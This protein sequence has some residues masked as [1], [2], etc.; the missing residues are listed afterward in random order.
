MKQILRGILFVALIPALSACF[1]VTPNVEMQQMSIPITRQHDLNVALIASDVTR[2]FNTAHEI[3]GACWSGGMQFAAA[4]YGEILANSLQ[5]RFSYLFSSVTVLNTVTDIEDY[6]A[7]FSVDINDAGMRFACGISPTQFVEIKGSLQSLREDGSP[8]WVSTKSTG[9]Y[10]AGMSY[11][12]DF[13]RIYGE[14]FSKAIAKLVDDWVLELQMI[15]PPQYAFNIDPDDYERGGIYASNSNSNFSKRNKGFS[16]KP[17]KIKYPAAPEDPDDIMV[18]IGNAN[19]SRQSKD[20]PDVTPAYSDA[21][22]MKK[23]AIQALGIREGNIID[24]RD[25][26]SA[27]I[28]SVF[29]SKTNYKGQL[30]DWVKPNKSK[31][32]VYY[33]GHGAPSSTDGVAYLVPVDA[34]AARI[35]L[36]GYPLSTLYNNLSQLSAQN[37]TVLVEACFSGNS[38]EGSVISNASPVYLKAQDTKIPNN[39]TVITAGSPNQ[40]ASWEDD[41]INS[42]FTKY[43]LRG[44]SG[45]ADQAPYG[46]QDGR[47]ELAEIER[48]LED[49]MTYFARRYYGRSQNV[50][51][52]VGGLY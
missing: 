50:Q 22:S 49:T 8:M 13:N 34:D 36:N 16:T 30:F 44:Q 45:E 20:I 27:Q 43:Y 26:T 51:I 19:Y 6:D 47:V 11:D 46:N 9:H 12:M 3:P 10:E 15:Q 23:Y 18:I 31:V 17:L 14:Q 4:P 21:E 42:L 33:V 5:N 39:I 35:E 7:V 29:G 32:F 40:V 41:K 38:Q 2:N 1:V 28:T 48:Y 25:A 37:V 52:R 24:L